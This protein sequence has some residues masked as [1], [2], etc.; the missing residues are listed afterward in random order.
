MIRYKEYMKIRKIVN[1]EINTK[2]VLCHKDGRIDI[3]DF[4]QTLLLED[5]E[6]DF[7][8]ANI[9]GVHQKVGDELVKEGKL[10]CVL[11]EANLK[12]LYEYYSKKYHR[13]LEVA[14]KLNEFVASAQSVLPQLL[15][16]SSAEE[17]LREH[18]YS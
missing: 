16:D 5:G 1:S 18:K 13:S 10:C 3:P 17:F 8:A 9:D 15:I 4:V 14:S 12:L 11:C 7:V 2:F 6:V